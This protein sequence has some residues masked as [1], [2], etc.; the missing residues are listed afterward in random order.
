[1]KLRSQLNSNEHLLRSLAVHVLFAQRV[2][3]GGSGVSSTSTSVDEVP[4]VR[5]EKRWTA[6]WENK[7][8]EN[9]EAENNEKE[10]NSL[11]TLLTHT[12][13]FAVLASMLPDSPRAKA[14]RRKTARGKLLGLFE[15]TD[16]FYQIR[17]KGRKNASVDGSPF[18]G[19]FC[20]L[21]VKG[22]DLE[23][24]TVDPNAVAN[25]NVNPPAFAALEAV[26]D[27]EMSS[28]DDGNELESTKKP[29]VAPKSKLCRNV[30]LHGSCR[31]EKTGCPYNHT[32]S[33][34]SNKAHVSTSITATLETASQTP[35]QQPPPP[36]EIL[37]IKDR[38]SHLLNLKTQCIDVTL[39]Y[40]LTLNGKPIPLVS[41]YRHIRRQ[42]YIKYIIPLSQTESSNADPPYTAIPHFNLGVLPTDPE[43]DMDDS[44]PDTTEEESAR[45][46][47][48]AKK[49]WP[50]LWHDWNCVR[51]ILSKQF[52]RRLIHE[53][54]GALYVDV[55]SC[56]SMDASESPEY[57]F[58]YLDVI[59][60]NSVRDYPWI[61]LARVVTDENA[62]EACKRARDRA[63]DILKSIKIMMDNAVKGRGGIVEDTTISEIGDQIQL[64]TD[65]GLSAGAVLDSL[66]QNLVLLEMENRLD[67][68]HSALWKRVRN[69]LGDEKAM[70]LKRRNALKESFLKDRPAGLDID[71]DSEED[72][73]E[74]SDIEKEEGIQS[75][76]VLK[77]MDEKLF[78]GYSGHIET[79]LS[80]WHPFYN[81]HEH[82]YLK[83]FL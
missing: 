37:E 32:P 82:I 17:F 1:M 76:S 59:E 36:P 35:K 14:I 22:D 77:S 44:I 61:V 65:V 71:D 8:T 13:A 54:Y 43:Y 81:V 79:L 41:L 62:V 34:E 50:S 69:L 67:G 83:N 5:S 63:A 49:N 19:A 47:S 26:N 48:I 33:I 52:L 20:H 74:N 80:V 25:K 75:A 12:S 46:N 68:F 55:K 23:L 39:A 51:G 40:L 45:Q 31:N 6:A 2:V 58:V 73:D 4:E 42:Y 57:R 9:K 30:K 56:S 60:E 21:V 70:A 7:E 38:L 66:N 28:S 18:N 10:N 15:K 3:L 72:D 24:V 29:F 11:R 53:Q 16:W 64:D 27:V 78:A